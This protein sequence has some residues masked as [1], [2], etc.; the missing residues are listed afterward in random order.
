MRQ[1]RPEWLDRQAL[2]GDIGTNFNLPKN[3]EFA[4]RLGGQYTE[5]PLIPGEQYGIGGVRSVRGYEER[6]AYGECGY[7]INVEF[8]SP[9]LLYN[10][11][12]LFFADAGQVTRETPHPAAGGEDSLSGAGAGLRWFWKQYLY[13]SLDVAQALQDGV[14]TRRRDIRAHYQL[15]LR[16]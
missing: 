15:F 16:F 5:Q 12:V 1:P 8:L 10:T 7:K 2:R 3:W 11:R 14:T 6:E 13:A 4:V 9:L